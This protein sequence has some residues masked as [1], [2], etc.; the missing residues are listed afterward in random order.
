M[1]PLTPQA[2]METERANCLSH[3]RFLLTFQN[4]LTCRRVFVQIVAVAT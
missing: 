2:K 4:L 1:P 3:S